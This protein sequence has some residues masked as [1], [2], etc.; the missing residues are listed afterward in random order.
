M[1]ISEK[2]STLWRKVRLSLDLGQ[3]EF[4]AKLGVGAGYVKEN[5]YIWH[6]DTGRV[7]QRDEKGDAVL[8][9]GYDVRIAS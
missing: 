9:E 8:M 6:L 3:K 7:T 2:T 5:K 1:T 4:A